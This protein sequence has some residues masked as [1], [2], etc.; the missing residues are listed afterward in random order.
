MK[1]FM[2]LSLK[3]FDNFT[4]LKKLFSDS[5]SETYIL[6]SGGLTGF[7]IVFMIN[8]MLGLYSIFG[9]SGDISD[10]LAGV[11]LA[12]S[13]QIALYEQVIAWENIL[14]SAEDYSAFQKNYHE[15][16][17]R[18]ESVQNKLFDL[19]LQ[20]A[21]SRSLA[22]GI[23]KTRITHKKITGV[24]TGHIVDMEENSFKNI[25]QKIAITRGMEDEL[26]NSLNEIALRIAKEGD[27]NNFRI[28]GRYM[29]FA[30]LSTVVFIVLLVY[31]G[32]QIGKRL[33]KTHNILEKMVQER[34]RGY[35]EA[36]LS[37]RHEI[38]EH[39]K[40]ER[41]LLISRN[42]TEEKNRQLAI[43]ERRYRMIV[44]GTS[45][46]IFT[47]DDNWYFK[48]ANDAIKTEL[49]IPPGEVSGLRLV[50]LI[51]DD[52]T[53]ASTLRRIVTE[54][55]EESRKDGKNMNFNAQ[56]KTPNLIEP[57]EFRISI[58]FINIDGCGEIIGKA[59][60]LSDDTFSASFI[61][62]KSEYLIRN[63]LF[64]ADDISRRITINLQKYM[65]KRD[66]NMIRI[67]LREIIIN[68]IEHG[69]LE[70]SFEEKTGAILSEKYFEF[71]NERQNLPE[72]RDKRVKIEYLIS[73]SKAVYKITDQGKGFNHKKYLAG[74]ATGDPLLPHGRGIAMVES[75]FDEVKYNFRGNQ[76]L[77]VKYLIKGE[78]AEPDG[79][80]GKSEELQNAETGY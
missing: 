57:V 35:V 70:I 60:R 66:V 75:I 59:V 33:L 65:D 38:E 69:N 30:F 67:G 77:L 2:N 45:E 12:R 3:K 31:Y 18:G 47:L 40:T 26:L 79:G 11:N 15:F 16:S 53:D 58:E 73:P 39:K 27:K 43:S 5:K 54:K 28:S 78:G 23:E 22:D 19:K 42:E 24:F 29:V 44:E 71:V 17:R 7:F 36:N 76:V 20:Y 61:S 4:L 51:C 52:I 34:T 6:I 68:S 37:L 48:T 1:R 21:N 41:E 9:I 74:A 56:L 10:N 14:I 25:S 62:E 50:D 46:I 13:T 72:H 32:R 49:R 64:E 63:L 8:A 80:Y 55:L